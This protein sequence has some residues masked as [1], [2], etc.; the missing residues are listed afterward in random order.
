MIVFPGCC[1]MR[2]NVS[3]L[4]VDLMVRLQVP[5]RRL[6]IVKIFLLY[7][8]IFS[9]CA[10]IF[11][12]LLISGVATDLGVSQALPVLI[13]GSGSVDEFTYLTI[14]CWSD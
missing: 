11:F 4:A 3:F 9:S 2:F 14:P 13:R 8:Y 12:Y 10:N 1:C 7:I 6:K 5:F